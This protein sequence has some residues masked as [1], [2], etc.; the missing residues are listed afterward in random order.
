MGIRRLLGTLRRM[1]LISP[2][3]GPVPGTVTDGV[4]LQLEKEIRGGQIAPGAVLAVKE[5]A[6]RFG[7]SRTPAKEALL[8]LSTAGLVNL[9][10]RRGAVVTKLP[11]TAIFGM[12]EVLV[13]LESEAARLAAR[14]MGE[15]QRQQLASLNVAAAEAVAQ[16]DGTLYGELNS[17]IHQLIYQGAG[18]DFLQRQIVEIRDRLAAYRPVT[19]DR[20]GRMKAS[21]VEHS[22]IVEAIVRGDEPEAQRAM[23][24]HITVGGTA[25]AELMLAISRSTN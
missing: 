14:R 21:H 25:Q 11:A 5:V 7:I 13:V 19:F 10:P 1:D 9:Q 6:E 20:P 8:Q 22:A 18:N 3:L 17:R 4:R 12:L 16:G 2:A 24:A 23:T 15:A